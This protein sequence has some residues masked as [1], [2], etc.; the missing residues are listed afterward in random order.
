MSR[1]VALTGLPRSGSTL[2]CHLVGASPDAIALVEPMDVTAL[3]ADDHRRAVEQVRAFFEDSAAT[4]RSQRRAATVHAAGRLPDN[5]YGRRL[6]PDGLRERTVAEVEAVHFDKPLS[7]DF[8]LLVKHNAAFAALLPGLA[9][10]VDVLGLVRNPLAVL[11][12]WQTVPIP[13]Q[14]GRAVAAEHFDPTLR[15]RLDAES[16]VLERQVLLL[17]WFFGRY[18]EHLPG[19]SI[20]RYERVAADGGAGLR[21]RLGL[22]APAGAKALEE[23]NANAAYAGVDVARLAD[24]LLAARGAWSPLYADTEIAALATRLMVSQ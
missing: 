23:R 11:C 9:E 12:S 13:P 7:P 14:R 3:D 20:L 6:A 16:E 1:F 24:R 4:L 10:V 21:E 8:L 2:C 15:R 18:V 17:D 22:A 19:G 5:P